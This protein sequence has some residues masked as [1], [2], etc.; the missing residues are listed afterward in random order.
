MS[1]T[2]HLSDLLKVLES[3]SN[4][5]QIHEFRRSFEAG[6]KQDRLKS[7]LEQIYNEGKEH[8]NDTP[9]ALQNWFTGKKFKLSLGRKEVTLKSTSYQNEFRERL[10]RLFSEWDQSLYVPPPEVHRGIGQKK[11][12]EVMKKLDGVSNDR[13]AALLGSVKGNAQGLSDEEIAE[14]FPD[15]KSQEHAKAIAERIKSVL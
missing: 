1:W 15:A 9:E 8:L 5:Q 13:L 2:Q 6:R 10:V 7:Q 14:L 11:L 3:E 4:G 12:R